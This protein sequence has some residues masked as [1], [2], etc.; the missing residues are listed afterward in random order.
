MQETKVFK[1]QEQE[2]LDIIQSNFSEDYNSIVA[3]EEI[4][5]QIL[6]VEVGGRVDRT[7]SRTDLKY[8]LVEILNFLCEQGDL[9]PGTYNIDCTW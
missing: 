9:E 5:N 6:V 8:N 1:C 4:G 7:P 2:V 3:L